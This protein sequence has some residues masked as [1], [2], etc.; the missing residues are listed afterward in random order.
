MPEHEQDDQP[1]TWDHSRKGRLVGV[2][3]HEGDTWITIR[4]TEPNR[5]ADAGESLTF[6]RSLA[7]EVD[8]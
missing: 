1:R 2:V 7:T 5:Q 8:A 6:R 3:V 4:C